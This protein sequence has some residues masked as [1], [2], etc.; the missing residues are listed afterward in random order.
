MCGLCVRVLATL[1][2]PKKK[3]KKRNQKTKQNKNTLSNQIG[4]ADPKCKF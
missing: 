4:V 3:K 2:T 1:D